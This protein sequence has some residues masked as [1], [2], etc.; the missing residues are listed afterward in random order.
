MLSLTAFADELEREKARQR[1]TDAMVR[2]AKAGHV[3]GGR[4]FGYDNLE[5]LDS[6][7]RRAHV[8]RRINETEAA[9]VRRIFEMC[10]AGT[11]YSRI[12][13]LLNAERAPSPRPQQARPAD[14][15]PSSVR[16]ILFRDLYRGVVVWNRTQKR[17]RWGQHRQTARPDS[18]WLQREA[19]ELR[20]VSDELW[21]RVHT[22]IGGIRTHLAAVTGG[23]LG[24]R[25]RDIESRYLLPGFARCTV[26]GGGLCVMTRSHGRPGERVGFYGCLAHHKR[27]GAVCANGLTI[28]ME[29]V[30]EAVLGT[31][32]GEVLRP[33]V[34]NAI[35]A[36]VLDGLKPKALSREADRRRAELADVDAEIGRLTEAIAT[37]G[38]LAPL[39]AALQ[40]R[41][42][43]REALASELAALEA[44]APIRID[45]KAVEAQVREWLTAWRALLTEQVEDGREL[46]RQVLAGPLRFT[47]DGTRYRFE[48]EA[49]IGRRCQERLDSQLMWRPHRDSNPGFSLERAAS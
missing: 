2:K 46:L 26:C 14:W 47:P 25:A 3:T 42:Q 15:A 31:L 49:A 48:G 36:G 5:V 12:A 33:A 24:A 10:A 4:V 1:V 38:A 34:I 23:R 39:L 16:E 11:G 41:Q 29:R 19:P 28:R 27:G 40:A 43:R 9:I 32:G 22:R 45:R 6:T 20:I 17:D 30:N 8:E 37:R 44:T 21:T 7:G 35:V 13:K 18:E